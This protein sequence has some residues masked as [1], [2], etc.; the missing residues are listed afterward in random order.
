MCELSL[1]GEHF[2]LDLIYGGKSGGVECVSIVGLPEIYVEPLKFPMEDVVNDLRL[3]PEKGFDFRFRKLNPPCHPRSEV[4]FLTRPV[5]PLVSEFVNVF[6]SQQVG[7]EAPKTSPRFS[8]KARE[9]HSHRDGFVV[10]EAA[11][12]SVDSSELIALGGIDIYAVES[13]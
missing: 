10:R 12:V 9:N 7:T 2:P 8:S 1:Q 11:K 3:P 6:A 4:S 13:G 5:L